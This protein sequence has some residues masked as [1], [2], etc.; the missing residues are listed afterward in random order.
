M[1]KV[2]QLVVLAII[3]SL[4]AFGQSKWSIEVHGGD[5][6][7]LPLPLIIK[8]NGNP[9]IKI[10]AHYSTEALTLPVYWDLRLS[11][12]KEGKSI[13]AE[14]IHHKLYLDNTTSEIEKFNISHGF[15]MLFFNRGFEK[16]KFRVHTGIGMVIIHPES[17]IRGLEFG[18]STNDWDLGYYISGPAFNLAFGRPVRLSNRFFLNLEGKTTAA[19]SN[20]KIAKGHATVFNLAF[21]LNIGFGVDF[22]R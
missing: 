20:A 5:V 15:N 2:I 14:L 6:L 21:H 17:R 16:R 8:Q 4:G 13:E 18:D 9:P 19:Y 7:N 1:S 11:R 22:F 3:I 12:W 10:T